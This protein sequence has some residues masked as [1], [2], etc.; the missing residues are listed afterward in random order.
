MQ[1]TSLLT[2]KISCEADGER[3]GGRPDLDKKPE[4]CAYTR[5][6]PDAVALSDRTVGS[7]GSGPSAKHLF[8]FLTPVKRIFWWKTG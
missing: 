2:E 8:Q 3:I 4:R 7:G 1:Q 5:E 6:C